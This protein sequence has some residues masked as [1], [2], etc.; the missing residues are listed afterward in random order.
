MGQVSYSRVETYKQCPKKY[1]YRYI[2]QAGEERDLTYND[3]LILGL[4]LH[5]GME[6]KSPMAAVEAYINSFPICYTEHEGEMIK[7]YEL[8][9]LALN[10]VP[11][12]GLPEV[13]IDIEEYKGFID[14]LSYNKKNDTWT[15]YDYKYANHKN[16]DRYKDSSQLHVYKHYL[17]HVKFPID[18]L[19]YVLIPKVSTR[20]KKDETDTQYYERIRELLKPINITIET[21]KSDTSKFDEWAS[22]RDEML[23]AQEFPK[24][25]T[26]LC[27]WCEFKYTCI[28]GGKMLPKN[29][30]REINKESFKK[31]WLYGAPFSGKTTFANEFPDVLFLN[32]DGNIKYVNSPVLP[33]KDEIIRNGRVTSTKL[34]WQ[35]FTEAI[36]DLEQGSDFKTVVV[37]L[38]EDVYEHCRVY[39]CAKN[40]W[41]HESDNS[42]KAYDVIRTNFFKQIRRL[43][44]LDYNVVLISH[45]D[46]SK[47]I[48]KRTADKITA[49]KP[50]IQDK[51]A[52][53]IAG[54][55][56]IVARAEVEDDKY[57]LKFKSDSVEFGGG[58][59][60]LDKE[61]IPLSYVELDKLYQAQGDK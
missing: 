3:P 4:A 46:M 31:L 49:I 58:R 15:I 5:K 43:C 19:K 27:D 56:D 21:I 8:V 11:K 54:M 12:D 10:K 61:V 18:T 34:A 47:D 2:E 14:F 26:R 38:L 45:L 60:K 20:L 24:N 53:K 22:A 6:L 33:I 52:N 7:L 28:E 16:F 59:L 50:N 29:E 37:D 55:V 13:E 25:K 36:D 48:T 23:T 9:K 32:T 1:W 40:Q 35:V 42:F 44:N 17:E 51:I 30:K 39:E 41:E 57:L